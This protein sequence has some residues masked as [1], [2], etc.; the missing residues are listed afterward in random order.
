MAEKSVYLEI[1]SKIP[2][3]PNPPKDDDSF[4]KAEVPLYPWGPI[5]L[6]KEGLYSCPLTRRRILGPDLNN[7]VNLWKKL[8]EFAICNN[9]SWGTRSTCSRFSSRVQDYLLILSLIGY[10][11][12]PHIYIIMNLSHFDPK[13]LKK[14]EYVAKYVGSSTTDW[15]R[16]KKELVLAFSP[17]ERSLLSKR[18]ATSKKF[19]LNDFEKSVIALWQTLTGICL[20]VDE[21]FLHKP[22]DERPPRFWGL[23]LLNKKRH[24][25]ALLRKQDNEKR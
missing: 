24:E 10:P 8:S 20:Q 14:I 19:F 18:H 2:Y 17:K 1:L 12:Q 15:F 5:A 3:P 21:N 13:L 6:L 22:E 4:P 25:E 16:V 11:P 7:L 9:Y 23:M